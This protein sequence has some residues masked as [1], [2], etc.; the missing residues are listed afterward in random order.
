MNEGVFDVL[1]AQ[2]LISPDADP[3]TVDKYLTALE[4]FECVGGLDPK[5]LQELTAS[6][7]VCLN[8]QRG[9]RN[10]LRA[11]LTLVGQCSAEYFNQHGAKLVTVL[12]HQVIGKLHSM[13]PMSAVLACQV[14]ERLI[15]LA[16]NFPDVSK[17]VTQVCPKI[18][19]SLV[20]MGNHFSGAL[21][22]IL[23]CLATLLLKY[24][25]SCGGATATQ[26][27]KFILNRISVEQAAHVPEEL[28]AKCFAVLPRLGGGGKDGVNHKESWSK[29]FGTTL[30]TFD[31]LITSITSL[32]PAQ[33]IQSK[34]VEIEANGLCLQLPAVP[35]AHGLAKVFAIQHQFKV[36]CRLLSS[37][38]RCP[39]P[40]AKRFK[41]H[42]LISRI[43]ALFDQLQFTAL[44]QD[45]SH[46]AKIVLTAL[47][48]LYSSA[49]LLNLEV[50]K[51]MGMN[52]LPLQETMARTL[53][54]I[55]QDLRQFAGI[56]KQESQSKAL[57]EL[58]YRLYGLVSQM[59][60]TFE[61]SLSG[62]KQIGELASHLV[63]DFLPAQESVQLSTTGI[64]KKRK[65]GKSAASYL[66]NTFS[67]AVN[68]ISMGSGSNARLAAA[69]LRALSDLM[70]SCGP[71]LTPALHQSVQA[72]VVTSCL[73]MQSAQPS[74][75]F[76][77]PVA[78]SALYSA[79]LSLITG[80]HSRYPIPL[81]LGLRIF[82]HG[83]LHDRSGG[84]RRVCGT[85][86]DHCRTLVTSNSPTLGLDISLTPNQMENLV[87]DLMKVHT[88]TLSTSGISTGPKNLI[89]NEFENFSTTTANQKSS[90]DVSRSPSPEPLSDEKTGVEEV[91]PVGN[92]AAEDPNLA[93]LRGGKTGTNGS[94]R[95]RPK[96]QPEPSA[97]DEVSYEE[98][99][100]VMKSYHKFDK[101]PIF[102]PSDAV[103]HKVSKMEEGK[104]TA[105]GQTNLKGS[106]LESV[107]KA[108]QKMQDESS[109][110]R[111]VEGDNDVVDVSQMLS[112]FNDKLID[113]EC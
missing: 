61:S 110:E 86:L 22:E 92:G 65:K 48:Q 77:E 102:I 51:T 56:E 105:T 45:T 52:L 60:V 4:S 31:Q 40:Q 70:R 85:S 108:N 47:P 44:A 79:L 112:C 78:R 72:A 76:D 19:Q 5:D 13:N 98:S 88:I 20:L 3:N 104:R 50:V 82:H 100:E 66:G 69:S 63:A 54:R 59:S 17:Q 87:K 9:F 42:Q 68:K 18:V 57:S 84:V 55:M 43:N 62:L 41:P 73:S 99:R 24:P 67:N 32:L 103:P 107:D 21:Q 53:L 91:K 106:T 8:T 30:R 29:Y 35:S 95:K 46:E 89:R 64:P 1:R 75:P 15:I 23:S 94:S 7:N 39:F 6:I 37:L 36:V 27:E 113:E 109:E 93:L 10:G 14:M 49:I 96:G 80:G 12:T 97:E 28:L 34:G 11:A 26:A 33:R 71:Y 81:S 25:G 58:K 83:S 101:E 2:D 90:Q 16:P 111:D 74:A 38:L